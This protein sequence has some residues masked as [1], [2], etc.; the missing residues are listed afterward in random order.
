MRCLYGAFEMQ[1]SEVTGNLLNGDNDS[2]M[3]FS[4]TA[5][6]YSFFVIPQTEGF[7]NSAIFSMSFFGI[8]C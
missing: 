3:T 5:M 2:E 8:L 7:L 1:I 6:H 4:E